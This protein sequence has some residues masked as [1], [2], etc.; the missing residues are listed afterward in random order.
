[1]MEKSLLVFFFCSFSFKMKPITV[2][3]EIS[4]KKFRWNR[5]PKTNFNWKNLF[6]ALLLIN[7]TFFHKIKINSLN[8]QT[9]LFKRQV[10][11]VEYLF[12]SHLN[13]YIC[14]AIFGAH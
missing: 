12:I 9:G 3:F 11:I 5:N 2:F 6:M 7:N 14:K 1:M 10:R 4:N 8:S 13:I